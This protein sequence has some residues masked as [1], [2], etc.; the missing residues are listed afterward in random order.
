MSVKN[1]LQ[2]G[3]S[4]ISKINETVKLKK[5]LTCWFLI[6]YKLKYKTQ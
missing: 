2:K 1:C 4:V 5:Y 3:I 6:I